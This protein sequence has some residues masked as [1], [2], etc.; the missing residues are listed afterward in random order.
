MPG[1]PVQPKPVCSA[2]GGIEYVRGSP[3][4]SHP[5]CSPC[6][7]VWY[8]YCDNPKDPANVGAASMRLK[9]LGKFPWD[10]KSLK[11]YRKKAIW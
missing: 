10:D 11:D 4:H 7:I 1:T 5:I 9:A 3:Y 2:C 6:F 8:D